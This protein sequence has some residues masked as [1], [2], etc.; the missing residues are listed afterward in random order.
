LY[1][2]IRNAL[3]SAKRKHTIGLAGAK[4]YMSCVEHEGQTGAGL[5]HHYR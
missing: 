4:W 5:D 1:Q 2:A 3:I